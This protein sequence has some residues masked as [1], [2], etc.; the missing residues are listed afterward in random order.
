MDP[1]VIVDEGKLI[2]GSV[3]AVGSLQANISDPRSGNIEISVYDLRTGQTDTTVLHHR[4]EQDDHNVPAFLV[5][6]G[7]RY[8]AMS[9]VVAP[10]RP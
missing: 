9:A 7:G 6:P 8:L 2:V 4:L 3:R 10:I 1:R 5:R